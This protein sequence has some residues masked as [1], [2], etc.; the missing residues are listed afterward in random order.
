MTDDI[1]PGAPLVAPEGYQPL[2]W[3]RGFGRQMGPLYAK[4]DANGRAVLAFHVE[5]HHANGMN[6]VHGGMLM[7]FADMVFGRAVSQSRDRG[8]VTVRLTCDF[9]SG[10]HMGEWVEGAGDLVGED[11]DL[12]TVRGRIWVGERTI[13]TGTG[14]FKGVGAAGGRSGSWRR[15]KSAEA[16]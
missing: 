11:G 4:T 9:L 5:E 13:L 2:A 15:L 14:V 1:P 12:Y 7:A 16:G 3:A 10:A 6:N 8:W